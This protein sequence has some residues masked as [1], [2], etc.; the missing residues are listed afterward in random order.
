MP[1]AS[2]NIQ[3]ALSLMV[4]AIENAGIF[5]REASASHQIPQFIIPVDMSVCIHT[6]HQRILLVGRGG[7]GGSH[8]DLVRASFQVVLDPQEGTALSTWIIPAAFPSVMQ[9]NRLPAW[10]DLQH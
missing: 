9:H 2:K 3:D 8:T 1:F 7:E 4:T 5:P 6:S 10:G